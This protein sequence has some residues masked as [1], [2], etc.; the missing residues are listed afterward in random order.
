MKNRNLRVSS[1]LVLLCFSAQAEQ[2]TAAQRRQDLLGVA[3]S[4]GPKRVSILT[5]ALND[6][7]GA[8]RH[9]AVRLLTGIGHPAKNSLVQAL[10]HQDYVV[11]RTA[12]FALCS[13]EESGALPHLAQTLNDDEPL[14]RLAAVE[15]LARYRPRTEPVVKLLEKAQEDEDP[16]VRERASDALWPFYKK[17]ELLS[18]RKGWDHEV[19]LV[20]SISLPN[21]GWR[22]QADPQRSGHLKQWYEADFDDS[23]WA[24][25]GIDKAWENYG[26]VYDGIGWY[27]GKFVLP[28]KP[29]HLAA[30]IHFG[31]VDEIAWVWTNGQYIGQHDI[32]PYGW[33]KPFRLDVTRELKWGAENQITVRVYDS[34]FAGGIWK[35]IT[36]E[37]L[38]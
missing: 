31:A 24:P 1:A 11:R 20:Q 25:I 4:Q 38:E 15:I 36:I 21:E 17:V 32:G 27:R 18:Q 28:E 37:L 5:H 29:K 19:K 9:T 23:A 12:L 8:V 35:P 3:S 14:T 26:H 6:E 30:E 22:F 34:K 2:K 33:D 10:R 7:S 16:A 13:L